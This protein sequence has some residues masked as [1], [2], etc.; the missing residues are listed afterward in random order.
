MVSQCHLI[1]LSSCLS[2]LAAFLNFIPF[3]VTVKLYCPTLLNVKNPSRKNRPQI[4]PHIRT[5]HGRLA[6]LLFDNI[7]VIKTNKGMLC[8]QDYFPKRLSKKIYRTQESKTPKVSNPHPMCYRILRPDSTTCQS[9]FSVDERVHVL[10]LPLYFHQ[11]SIT[12]TLSKGARP[13]PKTV[14]TRMVC[15][16]C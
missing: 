5:T 3:Q 1:F 4:W 13:L 16:L 11:N 12:S 9:G 6:M 2:H 14:S 7:Y 8:K 10:E 15:A